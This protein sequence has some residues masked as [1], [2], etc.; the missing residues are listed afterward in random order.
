MFTPLYTDS[1]CGAEKVKNMEAAVK[2]YNAMAYGTN[3]ITGSIKNEHGIKIYVA[4]GQSRE[5]SIST[6]NPV[7]TSIELDIRSAYFHYQRTQILDYENNR[8]KFGVNI[9]HE[10]MA[11]KP[12]ESNE[13]YLKTLSW[14][15]TPF[16]IRRKSSLP[17][18]YL[19]LVLNLL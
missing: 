6:G 9:S 17:F 13:Y 14:T 18:Y 11:A 5:T 12:I 10:T 7:M 1:G 16:V 3:N 4:A 19:H 15:Y 2:G 8:F